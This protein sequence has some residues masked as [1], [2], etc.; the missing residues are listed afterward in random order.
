MGMGTPDDARVVQA[1][2]ESRQQLAESLIQDVDEGGL[3]I[4]GDHELAAGLRGLADECESAGLR[5]EQQRH[6]A[7]AE[8]RKLSTFNPLAPNPAQHKRN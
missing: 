3:F 4:A 2:F 1:R 8:V 7:A 5:T 6:D